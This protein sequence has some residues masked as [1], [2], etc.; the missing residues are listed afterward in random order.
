MIEQKHIIFFKNL[1]GDDNAHF[2]KAHQVAYCYDATKKRYEPDG[3]LFPRDEKDV[4]EILKYCNA[5]KII[6]VPRGA[7]SGFTGGALAANGGV[8]IAFEKYMNKILE[9]DLQNMVAIVQPG[10]VNI[11]LQKAVEKL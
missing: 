2:D 7:G 6:V 9:I 3:V 10:C 8:I 11:E 4:S 5:N 1:L